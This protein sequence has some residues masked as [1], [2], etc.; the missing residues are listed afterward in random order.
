MNTYIHATGDYLASG[1]CDNTIRVWDVTKQPPQEIANLRGHSGNVN[2]VA[3][4]AFGRIASGSNDNTIRLWDMT[5]QPPQEIA[6]LEGHS[7]GVCSVALMQVETALHQ[8]RMTRRS[9]CGT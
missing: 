7:G 1:F 9:V 5:T 6:T 3:F 8:A 4:D 2:S